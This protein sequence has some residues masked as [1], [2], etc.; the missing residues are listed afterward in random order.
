MTGF[1]RAWAFTVLN[2]GVKVLVL[3]WVLGLLG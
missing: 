2:W 3:A 1:A